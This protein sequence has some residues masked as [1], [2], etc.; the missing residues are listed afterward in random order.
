MATLQ[1]GR[2]APASADWRKDE[3]SRRLVEFKMVRQRRAEH[4]K[5][6]TS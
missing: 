2:V 4:L 6:A 5:S 3:R 1:A